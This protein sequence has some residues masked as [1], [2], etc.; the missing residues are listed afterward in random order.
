MTHEGTYAQFR[1]DMEKAEY[2]GE[3]YAGRFNDHGPAVRTENND[4]QA[5]IC[6]TSVTLPWD[7][8]G[9]HWVVVC[10]V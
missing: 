4:L 10:P 5:V 8:L 9:K 1:S 6:S 3:G 2:P 7:T